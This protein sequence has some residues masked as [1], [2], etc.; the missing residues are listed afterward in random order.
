MCKGRQIGWFLRGWLVVWSESRQVG[1]WIGRH[2]LQKTQDHSCSY[3]F[4]Y[5][6]ALRVFVASNPFE[7][8]NMFVQE[9]EGFPN[10][11]SS[12]QATKHSSVIIDCRQESGSKCPILISVLHLSCL[13]PSIQIMYT[14]ITHFIQVEPCHSIGPQ[15]N[16]GTWNLFPFLKPTY[17]AFET[18]NPV[19][20]EPVEETI[21]DRAPPLV[22]IPTYTTSP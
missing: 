3:I 10:Y 6:I 12:G 21:Q 5:S 20:C 9:R 18:Y 2:T 17:H 8:M 13:V 15:K 1:R 22:R 7:A 19:Q 16:L 14:C 4:V 11:G